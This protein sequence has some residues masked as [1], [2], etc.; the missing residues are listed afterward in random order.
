MAASVPIPGATSA[1]NNR[2]D[3]LATLPLVVL[4][5]V[6]VWLAFA[7]GAFEENV[8]GSRQTNTGATVSPSVATTVPAQSLVPAK[9]FVEPSGPPFL[10]VVVFPP[11]RVADVTALLAAESSLRAALGEGRREAAVIGA[12]DAA[13][14]ERIAVTITTLFGSIPGVRLNAIAVR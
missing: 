8:A 11:E 10:H 12:A 7:R 5:A 1:R 9:S 4:V 13:E 2:S 6:L 14:A 3:V